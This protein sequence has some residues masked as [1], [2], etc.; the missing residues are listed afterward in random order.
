MW[1]LT[2][3]PILI[4]HCTGWDQVLLHEGGCWSAR[5]C[6]A[7]SPLLER[8]RY[9]NTVQYCHHTVQY[10]HHG[11]VLSHHGATLHL[12][13]ATRVSLW[14]ESDCVPC[15]HWSDAS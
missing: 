8:E 13:G 9:V 6:K 11:T 12:I 1:P 10:C 14:T 5:A 4:M 3:A 2:S 7:C 15:N